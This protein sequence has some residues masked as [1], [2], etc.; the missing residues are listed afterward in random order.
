MPIFPHVGNYIVSLD[1]TRL[2]NDAQCKYKDIQ[3][4]PLCAINLCH[5][6]AYIHICLTRP[7]QTTGEELTPLQRFAMFLGSFMLKVTMDFER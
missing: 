3:L 5:K 7:I 1:S 4:V 6:Y 2:F